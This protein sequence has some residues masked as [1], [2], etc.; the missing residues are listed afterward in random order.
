MREFR[1][2][3]S[4]IVGGLIVLAY[5]YQIGTRDPFTLT[6][7]AI[8]TVIAVW[9][10]VEALQIRRVRREVARPVRALDRRLGRPRFIRTA[11]PKVVKVQQSPSLSP[12]TFPGDPAHQTCPPTDE[13]RYV[14]A[15]M[16]DLR[17]SFADLTEA[18]LEAHF[19]QELRCKWLRVAEPVEDI[20]R[21]G[22]FVV[23]TAKQDKRP[24]G[25]LIL[26]MTFGPEHVA[27]VVLFQKGQVLGAHGQLSSYLRVFPNFHVVRLEN[28]E[29]IRQAEDQS[30]S[31]MAGS[32]P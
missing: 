31:N 30:V 17:E 13:R 24:R 19:K 11:E 21:T 23:V 25:A 5:S 18:H 29:L 12:P 15:T 16:A 3:A 1:S 8:G 26:E 20:K 14:Q 32:Q 22:D 6:L 9:V 27:Q 2:F 10:I 28:C 7:Q 4:G